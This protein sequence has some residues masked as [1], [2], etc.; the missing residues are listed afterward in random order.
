MWS[1]N[2][3]P[4]CMISEKVSVCTETRVRVAKITELYHRG[5]PLVSMVF[6]WTS[7]SYFFLLDSVKSWLLVFVCVVFCCCLYNSVWV[8]SEE[9]SCN[10]A[11]EPVGMTNRTFKSIPHSLVPH[12]PNWSHMIS[13]NDPEFPEHTIPSHQTF[14]RMTFT[15]E[16]EKRLWNGYARI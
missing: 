2:F 10:D 4:H 1:Q 7:F 12:F 6:T 5:F 14:I 9:T 8:I 13:H 11:M 3:R 15:W 16:S